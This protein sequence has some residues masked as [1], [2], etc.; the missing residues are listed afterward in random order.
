MENTE[1]FLYN[2]EFYTDLDQLIDY[3]EDNE[4]KIEDLEDDWEI[5]VEL[6]AKEGIVKLDAKWITDKIDD[7]RLSEDGDEIER[8]TKILNKYV[9]F[10]LINELMP[11]LFY[12]S[13]EKVVLTKEDLLEY[14]NN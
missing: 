5:E 6:T 11:K 8:A 3:V 2:D 10:N 12:P 13:G 9:D 1:N 7:E 14:K 4:C